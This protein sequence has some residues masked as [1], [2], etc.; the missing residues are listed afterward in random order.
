MTGPQYMEWLTIISVIHV[1]HEILQHLRTIRNTML[2]VHLCSA[3]VTP[4]SIEHRAKY[5]SPT[6]YGNYSY[7]NVIRVNSSKVTQV[8]IEFFSYRSVKNRY[9]TKAINIEHRL[10]SLKM[11][12][13][14]EKLKKKNKVSPD[15]LIEKNG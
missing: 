9:Q 13:Y 5:N 6:Q 1:E 11:L 2:F 10:S 8:K 15:S 4:S 14:L 3:R 12:K 7:S